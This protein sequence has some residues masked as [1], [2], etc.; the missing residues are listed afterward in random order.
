MTVSLAPVV[1]YSPAL[2]IVP[3]YECFNHCTYC[4]FRVAPHQDEWLSLAAVAKQLAAARSHAISEILVLSGEVHPRSTRRAAWL[5]RIYDICALAIE[6]GFLPHTN[7]GPLS[8]AEMA[9]LKTVNVS[10]GLMVEQV[11]PTLLTGVHRHAPS[12]LPAVRLE[13]LEQAGRLQIPFTTGVLLGIGESEADRIATLAAI[14]ASHE[15]WGHIQEVILQPHQPGTHQKTARQPFSPQVLAQFVAIARQQLPP[16]I[17]IQ[18]PPNLLPDND[19]VL[20]AIANGAR[21]LGGLGPMDEVNPDYPHPAPRQLQAVLA[22]AG[23]QLQP[24]LPLYPRYD[25]WLSE[26]LQAIVQ[27]WRARL[28]TML[29]AVAVR[30]RGAASL[31]PGRDGTPILPI[32]QA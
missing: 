24:R 13:Q 17:T 7:V 23:W 18:I 6:Q 1:T 32:S 27:Q 9:Q 20:A 14:A 11:T 16:D 5:Q 30:Q 8:A 19:Y 29:P 4:N 28:P 3:T 31:S 10:M 22:E 26:P 2:T 12:K 25:A 15:R 21:D